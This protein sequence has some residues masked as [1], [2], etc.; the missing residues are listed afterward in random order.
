MS[1]VKIEAVVSLLAFLCLV[2][3]NVLT[4]NW[5]GQSPAVFDLTVILLLTPLSLS[6]ASVTSSTAALVA[7]QR[8]HLTNNQKCHTLCWTCIPLAV[9]CYGN[10]DSEARQ[11]FSR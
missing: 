7:E 4:N 5:S 3:P 11:T 9:E 10:R 2:L 8:K 1:G 6:K